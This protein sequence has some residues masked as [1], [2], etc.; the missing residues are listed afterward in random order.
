MIFFHPNLSLTTF[1]NSKCWYFSNTQVSQPPDVIFIVNLKSSTFL[2]D[3]IF[4]FQ[5]SYVF[6]SPFQTEQE[7]QFNYICLFSVTTFC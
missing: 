2:P 5:F 1:I 4:M 6:I 7:L 3:L